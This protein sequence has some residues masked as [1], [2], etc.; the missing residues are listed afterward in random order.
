MLLFLFIKFLFCFSVFRSTVCLVVYAITDSP[1]NQ[2]SSFPCQ[3]FI[4]HLRKA[5]DIICRK[6]IKTLE[7]KRF[8]KG[9]SPIRILPLGFLCVALLGALLL[10]LPIASHGDPLSFF[11]A[12]FTATS[13]SCVTGLVVVDT[14]THFTLFGQIVILV[15]IQLGGLGFMT[16]ATLLFRATRKRISRR[17]RMT[18]AESFGEDRLQGVIRLCMSAVKYT[19][20]I[21]GCGAALLCLRFVPDFGLRGIWMGIFHS[22]SAFCNAGFDL[23]G[24]FASLTR[25][26][27]D[28]L[29]NF[30][31]MALIITGGLGFS[32]IVELREHKRFPKLSM[33]AKLV[34]TA[35]GVLL[36]SG[37]VLF[38]LFEAGNPATMGG[39]TPP[40]KLLAALF[41]SVTCRTAGFNTIPQ[42]TLTDASKFLSSILMIIGG[43]PA[44]TA[45]GIKVTSVA[46]L[47]LTAHA[48]IRNHRDTEVFGRRL[49][50][51]SV[52]RALCLAL[53][54]IL[55]L[56]A[57]LIGITFAE[58]HAH[59]NLSFLDFFFEATSALG[60]VGLTAGLTAA[61]ST[62]TRAI[63]C[64]LMYLGRAGIMT[65]A[66]AI[67]GR[68]EEPAIRYPEGNILIG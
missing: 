17:S 15:L 57:A 24:N 46:V 52:R 33:H 16:A 62:F 40:Q 6:M 26:V 49:S 5:R 2:Y 11:D 53:I 38:L 10:M 23:M 44:G 3:H 36:M 4:S 66:L 55:V 63:L 56:F 67:G 65:I 9:I 1:P 14:G 13:A 20:I 47:L 21:E 8:H 30:T 32:V 22:V 59:A 31:I 12:L 43:G 19:F 35:T 37:M 64:A 34:L 29:V 50:A 7:N 54:A 51:I 39:L 41:Q 68:T 28:P 58:Q 60:T 48:C 25:Y 27:G 18:L 42:E 61:A 45:G